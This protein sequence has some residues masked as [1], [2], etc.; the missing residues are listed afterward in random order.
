MFGTKHSKT[1]C[2]QETI[3]YQANELSTK[4]TNQ[5]AEILLSKISIYN[6]VNT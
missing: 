6:Q 1:N 5:N 2:L 3:D 4:H